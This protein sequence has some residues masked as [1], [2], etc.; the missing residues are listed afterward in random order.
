MVEEWEKLGETN[1]LNILDYVKSSVEILLN[2]KDEELDHVKKEQSDW[3]LKIR[4][5]MKKL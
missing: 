2:M 1:P 3:L 4:A 5:K